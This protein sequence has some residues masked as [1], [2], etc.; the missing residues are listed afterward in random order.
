MNKLQTWYYDKTKVNMLRDIEK[1]G[2]K[3]LDEDKFHNH[4]LKSSKK[5]MI[6]IL[7]Q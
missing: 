5:N 2:L 7:I 6:N 1:Y 4:I 3:I